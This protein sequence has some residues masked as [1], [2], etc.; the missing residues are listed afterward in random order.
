MRT[1][2]RAGLGAA[3]AIVTL[4]GLV[5]QTAPASATSGPVQTSRVGASINNKDD[6]A[7]LSKMMNRPLTSVRV[8]Y[9]RPPVKWASSWILATI[10]VHGT[11]VV[12]FQSGT[13]TQIRTFL[14]S[15]PKTLQCYATY[16]HEPEDNFTTA[17][18]K[19]AYRASWQHYAPA[20]RAAGCVPTLILMKWSLAPASGRH[21]RDWYPQGAVDLLGFDAYNT[22]VKQT[23]PA[24]AEPAQFLAPILAV[25]KDTG[26]PWGLAEVGSSIVI[27]PTRRA[28]WAHRVAGLAIDKNA[29][30]VNWWDGPTTTFGLDRATAAA[31]HT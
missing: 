16:Y 22:R 9:D 15:R 4:T 25:S 24:Y 2:L 13:P 19:T 10:P 30:F 31:W 5:A 29:K 28:E 27:S 3:T 12:S 20:I 26:L 1:L 8:Y 23:D 6:V 14:A 7:R 11:A 21:W 18:R 17:A